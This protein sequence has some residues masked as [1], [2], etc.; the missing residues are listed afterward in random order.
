MKIAAF[1]AFVA[2]AM[3]AC[4]TDPG[5]DGED[6]GEARSG[7]TQCG[8]HECAA[9]QYCEDP[10]YA[11]PCENG[12]LSNTNCAGDQICIKDPDANVGTC[13]NEGQQ[14]P[15]GGGASP[16]LPTPSCMRDA[17]FDFDCQEFGHPPAAYFCAPG[18][19]PG[20]G[21]VPHQLDPTVTCCP[22]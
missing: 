13:Q 14:S 6:S 3:V 16:T 11:S 19:Y 20:D 2:M 21:C 17:F 8:S 4:G 5:A 1:A 15:T 18:E 7:I 22:Q 9:G 10:T 12:C